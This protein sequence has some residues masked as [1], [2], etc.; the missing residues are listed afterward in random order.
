MRLD[1]VDA[2]RSSKVIGFPI[3]ESAAFQGRKIVEAIAFACLVATEHGLNTVPRATV[4]DVK[5]KLVEL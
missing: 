5:P 1:A 4:L 3:A 2:L